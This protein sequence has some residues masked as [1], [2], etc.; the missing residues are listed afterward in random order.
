MLKFLI[1]L[2][3]IVDNYIFQHKFHFICDAICGSDWWGDNDCRCWYCMKNEYSDEFI[4]VHLCDYAQQPD[5]R[6]KCTGAWTTPSWKKGGGGIDK[7]GEAELERR[8]VLG[9][10][11][12]A[13]LADNN[14]YYTFDPD[15]VTCK[16]CLE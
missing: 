5:I 4:D 8:K 16:K 3:D 15:K 10:P 6:I 9:I 14:N 1:H 11:L 12:D 2:A 7:L 13:H